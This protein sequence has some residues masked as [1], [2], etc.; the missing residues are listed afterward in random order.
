[1]S[2]QL[3]KLI[4]MSRGYKMSREE[5]RAQRV[6]FAFGNAAIENPNIT[7]E[8]VEKEDQKIH[9]EDYK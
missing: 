5:R 8:M 6:S 2:P 1:M 4:E 7:R 3:L 9:P